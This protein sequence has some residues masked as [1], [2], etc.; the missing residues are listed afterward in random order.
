MQ[1][2]FITK[3]LRELS[4]RSKEGYPILSKKEHLSIISDILT[5]W[6]LSEIEGEL[7]RNLT[8]SPEED[9]KYTHVGQGYYVKK[10]FYFVSLAERC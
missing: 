7:I 8:E 3:L 10:G 6:G 1:K 4:Y 5:E 9:A 2:K